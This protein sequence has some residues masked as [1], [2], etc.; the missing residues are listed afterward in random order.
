MESA[1]LENY[2]LENR[3]NVQ[4]KSS[5]RAFSNH[6]DSIQV[7]KPLFMKTKIQV[8]VFTDR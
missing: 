4:T 6:C 1:A 5:S 8:M 3:E 7:T 2:E